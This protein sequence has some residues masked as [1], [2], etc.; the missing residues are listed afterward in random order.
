VRDTEFF[1]SLSKTLQAVH[2]NLNFKLANKYL[3]F[4]QERG[5]VEKHDGCYKVTREGGEYLKKAR[6]LRIWVT[7]R[8]G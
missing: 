4:L 5:L 6:E 2:T 7:V 3:S 8:H 1:A